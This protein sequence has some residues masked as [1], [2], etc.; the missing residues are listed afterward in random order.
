[1]NPE[2]ACVSSF[3]SRIGCASDGSCHLLKLFREN[4]PLEVIIITGDAQ[5]PK[6]G[7]VK[8]V[9]L[10]GSGAQRTGINRGRGEGR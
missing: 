3:A 4:V 10:V 1:M 8:N 2:T 5:E 9:R 7:V 6:E